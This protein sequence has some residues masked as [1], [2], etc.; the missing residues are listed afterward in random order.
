MPAACESGLAMLRERPVPVQS[1][2]HAGALGASG[3]A[4]VREL[5][6]RSPALGREAHVLLITPPGF[7]ADAPRRWPLLM[8][9]HGADAGPSS[10][11][12]KTTLV[13]RCAALDAL[14]AMPE[15][16]QVGFYS[17]WHGVA[18]DG[19]RPR[20]ERFHLDEVPRLLAEHYR[21]AD[22]KAI[23]GVSMGG[24]GAIAYAAK[25]PGM[26]VAAASF[27][28]LLHTTRRGMP[29][30]VAMMLLRER[31]QRHA[32][33]GSPRRDRAVWVAN[34]PYELAPQLRGTALYLSRADGRP[35]PE[36]GVP[37]GCGPLERWVAPT[38]ESLAARLAALGIPATIRR[39]R[40]GHEWPTWR[41]ELERAWPFLVEAL[42]CP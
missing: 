10:W 23:A 3:A 16:G 29:A 4:R 21:C 31:E 15:A 12:E 19:T 18:R 17:D 25:R 5:R 9:M 40:G 2:P 27:S 20:W 13:E 38:T 39:G 35:P 6:V 8:L 36:D 37:R 41:R 1:A 7:S 26:F 28:G 22:N 34:D 14:V 33:W 30:F 42:G 11:I 24:Y 32:L